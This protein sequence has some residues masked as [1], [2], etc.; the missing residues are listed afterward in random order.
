MATFNYP[1]TNNVLRTD[2]FDAWKNK[3]NELNSHTLYVASLLGDFGNLA[4]NNKTVVGAFNEIHSETDINAARIGDVSTLS[5]NFTAA[6]NLSSAVNDLYSK[7]ITYTNDLVAAEAVTRASE[8]ST[9][10]SLI[11][12]V[13]VSSG[14]TGSGGYIQKTSLRYISSATSLAAAD[15][16]L[17]QALDTAQQELDNTKASVG[18]SSDG[19]L[20]LEGNYIL[21][22]VKESVI[23]LDGQ[24][25]KNE[26]DITGLKVTA[27]NLQSE[28]DSTQTG[29]GLNASGQ[30]IGAI[31]GATN[32]TD[33]DD[34]LQTQI[35]SS[36][37]DIVAHSGRLTDLESTIQDLGVISGQRLDLSGNYI[38]DLFVDDA[39]EAL[40][41]EIRNNELAIGVLTT[42]TTALQTELNAT[43]LAAGLDADGSYSGSITGA[44]S[45]VSAD[46]ILRLQIATNASNI[47]INVADISNA[48]LTMQSYL[49]ASI[50]ESHA[51]SGTSYIDN[52]TVTSAVRTLD[53]QTKTLA[54]RILDVE[55]SAVI[56]GEFDPSTLSTIA[57]SGSYADLTEQP[58][59][60]NEFTNGTSEEF[61][62][63]STDTLT[64]SNLPANTVTGLS[65]TNHADEDKVKVTSIAFSRQGRAGTTSFINTHPQ[66]YIKTVG[67]SGNTLTL[68]HR[69]G[70]ESSFTPSFP[71]NDTTYTQGEGISISAGN[72]ISNTA[73]NKNTW[74]ANTI[75]SEGYVAKTDGAV[76]KVW[77]TDS[78]GNPSWQSED[79]TTWNGYRVSVLE[80][81][82][83]Y[84]NSAKDPN[85]IY[86]IKE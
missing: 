52:Q 80:S 10:Q 16:L 79:D 65:I 41:T 60:L 36:N 14:L 61:F 62:V 82:A 51:Y 30:Y 3:T 5:S 48:D 54:D 37:Q 77:K 33:A 19:T 29:S 71:D 66:N 70:T 78:L 2:T 63:K 76:K 11:D 27:G 25:L 73:M 17:D 7:V 42:K 55:N 6:S 32:L 40:D 46:E 67:T 58:T 8:D 49:G 64:S 28:I 22:S 13:E 39:L 9:L 56:S 59:N 21:G 38:A 75:S 15:T 83:A 81:Q 26:S 84:D 74:K 68:T 23:A 34:L 31:E 47:S 24:A 85:T 43:Q 50:G 45:L 35:V 72:V 69:D 53:I 1:S 12:T 4:T 57:T 20:A 86:F 44:T 18:T